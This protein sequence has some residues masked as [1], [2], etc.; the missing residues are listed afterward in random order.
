[1]KSVLR[2]LIGIGFG[3][4]LMQLG[5]YKVRGE[6]LTAALLFLVVMICDITFFKKDNGTD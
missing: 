2:Y 4:L 6:I 1:M 5:R 3:I